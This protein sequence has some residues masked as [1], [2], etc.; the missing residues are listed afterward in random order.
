MP[1]LLSLCSRAHVPYSLCFA[2]IE[3]TTMRSLY[4][5]TRK[6]FPPSLVG[7]ESACNM[8]DWGSIHGSG[9]SPGEGNGNPL[10]YSCLE[11]IPRT[12]EPGGL[13]SMGHKSRTRLSG[14]TTTTCSLKLEKKAAQQQRPSMAKNKLLFFKKS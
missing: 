5:A 12:E 11:K 14:Y 13:Q 10:Q 9:R 6:G 1:Q 4:I 2:T 3:V 7:K 8:G